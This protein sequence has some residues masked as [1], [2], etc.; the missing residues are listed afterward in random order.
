VGGA[1]A[2]GA[3]LGFIVGSLVHDLRP[4][5]DPEYSGSR[6]GRP[7]P[8]SAPSAGTQGWALRRRRGIGCAG[9]SRRTLGFMRKKTREYV[10]LVLTVLVAVVYSRLAG[11]WSDAAFYGGGAALIAVI[12]LVGLPWLELAPDGAWRR[13]PQA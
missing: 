9:A 3:T 6:S 12:V 10:V 5:T 2:L 1:A 11:G 8:P 13:R 7:I 4:Q